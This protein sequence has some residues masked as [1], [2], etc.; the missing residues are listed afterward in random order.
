MT[1][2]CLLFVYGLL[3][4]GIRPP[5]T[6]R[7]HWTGSVR[8]RLYDL[9]EYPGAVDIGRV[10]DTFEGWIV[11]IEEGELLELDA[12]EDVTSGNAYRRILSTTM[13]GESVWIYEY[14]GP[15][16]ETTTSLPRWPDGHT[17]RLGQHQT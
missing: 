2:T 11:E 7:R 10:P 1:K 12:F 3:Q 9:G 17:E 5:R 4:P 8:G 16:P 14:I 6:M 15:V 13:A